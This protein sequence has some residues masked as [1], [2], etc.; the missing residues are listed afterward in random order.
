M[1]AFVGTG[2][3][4]TALGAAV[5][6]LED[7]SDVSAYISG[8]T[9]TQISQ[10]AALSIKAERDVNVDALTPNVTVGGVAAGASIVSVLLNGTTM[11]FIG[12]AVKV[13][14][15]VGMTIGK[16]IVEA[17]AN[18]KGDIDTWGVS[19]GMG[20]ALTVNLGKAIVNSIVKAYI[21]INAM[22]KALGNIIVRAISNADLD[23]NVWGISV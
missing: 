17:I 2:G 22:V 21:G 1:T 9:E 12:D 20:A 8:T 5:A 13:G 16:I 18:F 14:Q 11:A 23:V 7:N 4:G 19:A 15:A 10:G 6:I 3:L